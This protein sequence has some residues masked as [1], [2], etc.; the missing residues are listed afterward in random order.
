MT[1]P[2]EEIL[3]R[4]RIE[5]K[6]LEQNLGRDLNAQECGDLVRWVIEE[7]EA[8]GVFDDRPPEGAA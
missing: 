1:S 4:C 6:R 5:A 3:S 8:D 7:V 2:L